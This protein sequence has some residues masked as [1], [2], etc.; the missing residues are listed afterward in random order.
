M[1]LEIADVKLFG[2]G[3]SLTDWVC[4]IKGVIERIEKGISNEGTA[5]YRVRYNIYYFANLQSYQNKLSE[6]WVDAKT[7]ELTENNISGDIW[8]KIY[9]DIRSNYNVYNDI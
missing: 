9:D 6:I 5:I 3:I 2:N 4:S 7:L 8:T 1:G